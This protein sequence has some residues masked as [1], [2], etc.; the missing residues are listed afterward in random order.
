MP[1]TPALV[2]AGATAI[3][4]GGHATDDDLKAA[5]DVR[6]LDAARLEV[7]LA[8]VGADDGI[9]LHVVDVQFILAELLV[10]FSKFI[11]LGFKEAGIDPQI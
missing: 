10:F 6:R 8:D 7:D 2:D 4:V 11:G 5:K 1:N 3:A 9:V